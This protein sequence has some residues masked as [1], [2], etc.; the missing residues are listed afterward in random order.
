MGKLT[1][2]TVVDLTQFLPGPAMTVMMAG[3]ASWTL[4]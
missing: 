2:I 1:G 3:V 4:P